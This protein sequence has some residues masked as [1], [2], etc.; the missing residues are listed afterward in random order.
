MTATLLQPANYS[1]SATFYQILNIANSCFQVLAE[2]FWKLQNLEN[3][4]AAGG[5]ALDPAGGAYDASPDSLVSWE[6]A[7]APLGRPSQ[8]ISLRVRP[9][10]QKKSAPLRT[11]CCFRAV[12][13]PRLQPTR[14]AA[15]AELDY[16]LRFLSV[17]V[18]RPR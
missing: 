4:S 1:V 10:T 8:P 5:S 14:T 7:L 15:A 16:I 11:L 12:F 2:A 17:V 3:S 13:K 9:S 18:C 6:G